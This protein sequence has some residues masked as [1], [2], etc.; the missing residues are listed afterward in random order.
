MAASWSSCRQPSGGGMRST[1]TALMEVRMRER[2]QCLCT[3]GKSI[4]QGKD[5]MCSRVS[6]KCASKG[7]KHRRLGRWAH[8]SGCGMQQGCRVAGVEHVPVWLHQGAHEQAVVCIHS[9]MCGVGGWVQGPKVVR[10]ASHRRVLHPAGGT[11]QFGTFG[12]SACLMKSQYKPSHPMS[13][14]AIL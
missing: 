14:G 7:S 10:R 9:H 2:G 3:S 1:Y 12:L 5:Q 8:H 6:P 4:E 11:P 13:R